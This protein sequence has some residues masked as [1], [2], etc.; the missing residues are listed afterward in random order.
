MVIPL[1]DAQCPNIVIFDK[2]DSTSLEAKKMINTGYAEHGLIILAK[3]QLDGYGRYDRKWESGQHDLTFSFVIENER[4]IGLLAIY[5]FIAVLS[6]R[7]A[8]QQYLS[9]SEMANISFKWP[10][11]VLFNGKKIAGVIFEPEIRQ[12]R[13]NKIV[14]GIGININSFPKG[15]NYATSLKEQGI[16]DFNVEALLFAIIINFDQYLTFIDE[17]DDKDVY[18]EWLK[19]AD[20]LNKEIIIISNGREI[21]GVF[22]GINRGSLVMKVKDGV[23]KTFDTGDVFFSDKEKIIAIFENFNVSNITLLKTQKRVKS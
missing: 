15:I 5:P 7:K 10:N 1:F 11:D 20:N 2:L 23:N 21:K 22:L 6:I 3:N 13:I 19:Y 4:E 18:D 17:N 12:D 9:K 16:K 8:L 14:C